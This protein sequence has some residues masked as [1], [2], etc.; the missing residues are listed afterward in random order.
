[1]LDIKVRKKKTHRGNLTFESL[2]YYNRRNIELKTTDLYYLNDNLFF[3]T[4][5]GIKIQ[6]ADNG[7]NRWRDSY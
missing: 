4:S 5:T 2:Y 1:M 6:Q 3:Y 7:K